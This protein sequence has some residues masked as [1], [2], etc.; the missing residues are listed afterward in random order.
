MVVPRLARCYHRRH[1]S[2][3]RSAHETI[4]RTA[5]RPPK[6]LLQPGRLLPGQCTFRLRPDA[7]S[8]A[9]SIS[10]SAS[11]RSMVGCSPS[12][13][14]A[15]TRTST[16]HAIPAVR[17]QY[18]LRHI[19]DELMRQCRVEPVQVFRPLA[20]AAARTPPTCVSPWTPPRCSTA[21]ATSNSSCWLP[22][23]RISSHLF[24]N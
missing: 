16:P 1:F 14:R 23:M 15:R 5:D 24:S 8:L 9:I 18:F 11:P 10:C 12:L 17:R 22:V 2:P 7:T 3:R 4:R 19:P 13:L 21:S 20:K 6:L